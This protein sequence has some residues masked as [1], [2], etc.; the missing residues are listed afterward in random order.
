MRKKKELVERVLRQI[1][2]AWKVVEGYN[3]KPE[4]K[5]SF[6]SGVYKSS[7]EG[8]ELVLKKEVK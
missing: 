7:L 6:E 2:I 8:L 4:Y 5:H 3:G 1:S